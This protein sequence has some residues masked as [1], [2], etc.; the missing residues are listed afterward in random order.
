VHDAVGPVTRL[1]P[2]R[3][4]DGSGTHWYR[5]TSAE[6]VLPLVLALAEV[7]MTRPRVRGGPELPPSGSA[8]RP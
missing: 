7:L 1:A 3:A 8:G 4:A 2:Y 6:N 5:R